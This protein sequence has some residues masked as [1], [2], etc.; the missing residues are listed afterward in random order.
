MAVT[1]CHR[2]KSVEMMTTQMTGDFNRTTAT[3]HYED[4]RVLP[5]NLLVGNWAQWHKTVC[6]YESFQFNCSQAQKHD[7]IIIGWKHSYK[8]CVESLCRA[9]DLQFKGEKNIEF[10]WKTENLVPKKNCT[11]HRIVTGDGLKCLTTF[12]NKGLNTMA[13]TATQKLGS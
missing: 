3:L 2:V 6:F 8:V 7:A 11:I 4:C 10:W 12:Q 5:S 13:T 9:F 1:H